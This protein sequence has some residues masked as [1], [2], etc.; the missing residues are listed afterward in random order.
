MCMLINIAISSERNTSAKAVKERLSNYKIL[1][2]KINRRLE[3]K[4]LVVPCN[5]RRP[6][7][8]EEMNANVQ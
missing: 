8:H 2:I 1:K 7:S 4:T 5:C 6:D 3:I